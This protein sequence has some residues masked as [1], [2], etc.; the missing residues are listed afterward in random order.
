MN[1]KLSNNSNNLNKLV[2]LAETTQL[3][4]EHNCRANQISSDLRCGEAIDDVW[5]AHF[6]KILNRLGSWSKHGPLT[7]Q[8]IAEFKDLKDTDFGDLKGIFVLTNGEY[9]SFGHFCPFCGTSEAKGPLAA[10]K[11]G[12]FT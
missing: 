5:Y 9:T 10:D 6:E 2:Y 12:R 3:L 11:V 4:I 1:R 8:Q 7:S